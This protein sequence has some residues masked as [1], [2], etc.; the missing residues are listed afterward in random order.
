M[1]LLEV[2]PVPHWPGLRLSGE[3]DASNRATLTHALE[4]VTVPDADL[5]VDL[6]RVD[7]TDVGTAILLINTAR[8]LPRPRR[9][10]LHSPPRLLTHLIIKLWPTATPAT[11]TPRQPRAN[12]V[13]QG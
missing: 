2:T 9:L 5:H 3:I 4:A 13:L 11:G 8:R 7:F 12:L 10:I 1:P 6:R